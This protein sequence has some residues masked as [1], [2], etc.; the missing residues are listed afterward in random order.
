M[1]DTVRIKI[2][3]APTGE[4]PPEIRAAWVDMEMDATD[5]G[6]LTNGV[7]SH[8]IRQPEHSGNDY[9]YRVQWDHAMA[10]LQRYQEFEAKIWWERNVPAGTVLVFGKA[11][12]E[13]VEPKRELKTVGAMLKSQGIDPCPWCNRSE[14][15]GRPN[16]GGPTVGYV[17][18]ERQVVCSCGAAGPSSQTAEG[19]VEVWNDA[20][21]LAEDQEDREGTLLDPDFV[22]DHPCSPEVRINQVD[23]A[24]HELMGAI[25]DLGCSPELTAV[26]VLAGEQYNRIQRM[27]I[28]WAELYTVRVRYEAAL[29][30]YGYPE[31]KKQ[32]LYG[33]KAREALEGK[34]SDDA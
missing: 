27:K 22:F 1:T 17:G 15:L 5:D 9:G 21:K 26:V 3:K 18:A 7:L 14:F 6:D 34:E 30:Y 12:C 32:W 4:A 29:G 13:V 19:A 11:F 28:K 24:M 20:G 2:V 23:A 8:D 10:T 31:G 16:S 25:E 33:A